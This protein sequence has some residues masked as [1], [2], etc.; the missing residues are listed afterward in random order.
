MKDMYGQPQ[1]D[2]FTEQLASAVA[3]LFRH[4][5]YDWAHV[6]AKKAANEF[7]PEGR[8]AL[9]I[10]N[11]LFTAHRLAEQHGTWPIT[12]TLRF[13]LIRSVEAYVWSVR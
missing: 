6:L 1:H 10:A 13:E 11:A 5:R 7:V 2:L 3:I 4:A 12:Q 8:R 9:W